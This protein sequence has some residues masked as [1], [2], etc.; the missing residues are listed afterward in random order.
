[1]KLFASIIVI[2]CA[3]LFSGCSEEPPAREHISVLKKRIFKLQEA[4][5][6]HNRSSIDSLLST[7]IIS[8]GQSSD[9][10]LSFCWGNEGDFS[11]D[12]LGDCEIAYT[13]KY[14]VSNCF[15]MDSSNARDRPIRLLYIYQHDLWL[16]K[17]FE[18]RDTSDS[19]L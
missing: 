11:F 4:V 3:M 12:R 17:K 15:V 1:M 18:P 5:K 8:E 2:A 14:A 7:D 16:L 9:S 19:Q 6:N 13:D 10:L